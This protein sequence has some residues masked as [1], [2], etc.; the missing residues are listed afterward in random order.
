MKKKVFLA[1]TITDGKAQVDQIAEKFFNDYSWRLRMQEK[2][3]A[4][5]FEIYFSE[6]TINL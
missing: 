1:I 4:G 2:A 5:D 6:A 3:E